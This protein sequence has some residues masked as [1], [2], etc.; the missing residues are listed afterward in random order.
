MSIK[1]GVVFV[2][3]GLSFMFAYGGRFALRIGWGYDSDLPLRP[4]PAKSRATHTPAGRR[5]WCAG[6]CGFYIG[7]TKGQPA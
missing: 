5:D 6:W 2:S 3:K 7:I 1:A 4:W